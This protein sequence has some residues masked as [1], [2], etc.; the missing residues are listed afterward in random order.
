MT[1]AGAREKTADEMAAVLH[2]G[3]SG[4]KVHQEFGMMTP[5]VLKSEKQ[6]SRVH[7][8]N[9]LWGQDQQGFQ[10]DFLD[11]VEKYYQGGFNRWISPDKP[12]KPGKP[13]TNGF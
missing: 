7:V 4:E 8:A 9:A 1:Y 10:K 5:G 2:Y 6:G 13:S 11:L 3:S 12:N